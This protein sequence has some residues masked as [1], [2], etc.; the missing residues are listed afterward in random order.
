MRLFS[1]LDG[2]GLAVWLALWVGYSLWSARA[3][4]APSLMSTLARYRLAWMREAY[5]RENRITDVALGSSLMQ[6]AT[7]FSSTTLLILG[8]LFAF[9]G[10]ID[11]SVEV[12]RSLP[13]AT[14]STQELVEIKALCITG[15]FTI[16]FVRFTWSQ[17]QFNLMNIVIGAYP[18][19]HDALRED[20]P[21]IEQA[22]R[23]NQLAGANFTQGLRTYYFALPLLLWLVNPWFL[24]VSAF[25]MTAATWWMEFRSA[26]VVALSRPPSG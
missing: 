11:Q 25:A 20:D 3:G 2:I 17:R 13:F 4:A 18:S 6:S 19:A 21:M 8:G 23:L 12:V 7:F 22:A 24:I 5:W 15:V 16:A 1:L 10:T 26:T 14:R 9:L